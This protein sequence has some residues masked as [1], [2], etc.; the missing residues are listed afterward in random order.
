MT[1]NEAQTIRDQ[2][3]ALAAHLQDDIRNAS[4]RTEHIRLT[5]H[6]AEAQR[7]VEQIDMLAV[8]PMPTHY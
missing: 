4:T 2:A 1:A 7:L 3:A 6:A 8:P 5:Q